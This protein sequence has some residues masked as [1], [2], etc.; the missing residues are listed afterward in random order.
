[1]ILFLDRCHNRAAKAYGWMTPENKGNTLWC[2]TAEEA[3][4]VLRDKAYLDKLT[5]VHL[6]HDLFNGEHQD[7]NE[8]TSG[9]EVIRCLECLGKE[10]LYHISFN[11]HT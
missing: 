5:R 9:M 2:Q 6:E 10:N 1:M 7:P 8:R 3:I 11:I 4:S